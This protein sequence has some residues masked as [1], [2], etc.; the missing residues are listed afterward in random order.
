MP[1]VTPD[2]LVAYFAAREDRRQQEIAAAL[3]Q[4]EEQMAGFLAEHAADPSL[5]QFLARLI[6]ESAIQAWVRSA[7][8]DA[9]IPTDSVILYE[10]LYACRANDDKCPAWRV[11]D[12]RQLEDG[13]DA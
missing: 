8:P 13:D 9:R 5:P 12:G 6:R 1:D 3:P 4:L 2:M 7:S 10:T 11:F